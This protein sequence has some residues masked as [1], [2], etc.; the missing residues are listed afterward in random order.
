MIVDQVM[1]PTRIV[2]TIP[3]H[4]A[5]LR[6]VVDLM[7]EHR[8]ADSADQLA[9]SLRPMYPRV[10]VFERQLSGERNQLYVYR[11]GRY[12]PETG[13]RW[14]E[15]PDVPCAHVSASTGQLTHVTGAWASLM[16]A[17]PVDLLGRHFLEFIVPE[18]RPVAGAMFE[19]VTQ[20]RDVRSEAVY[21][22]S[23]GVPLRLEFRALRSGDDIQVWLRPTESPVQAG[24]ASASFERPQRHPA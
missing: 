14:W 3:S 5:V 9:E 21:L 10:A 13:G 23:D 15:E 1:T 8:E 18:A 20:E 2:N 19:A 22:R 4:D 6:R 24:T 11:D 17:E 12:E 7:T 16:R